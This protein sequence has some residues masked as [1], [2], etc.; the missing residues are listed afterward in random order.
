M[1]Y[2]NNIQKQYRATCKN[3]NHA[4]CQSHDLRGN[5]K[6]SRL[7]AYLREI[8]YY[9]MAKGDF[10]TAKAFKNYRKKNKLEG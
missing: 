6:K 8:E 7:L 1:S 3:F 2:L 9:F 10:T 5:F 4:A